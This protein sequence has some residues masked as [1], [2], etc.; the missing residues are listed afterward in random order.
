MMSSLDQNILESR[1]SKYGAQVGSVTASLIW[2]DPSDLRLRADVKLHGQSTIVNISDCNREAAGGIK[3]VV[4]PEELAPLENIS[5][6]KPLN[7]EYKIYVLNGGTIYSET[8]W[9]GKFKDSER[10]IPFKVY[11]R[12]GGSMQVF[13]GVWK[14][15]NEKINC[16]CLYIFYK[17]LLYVCRR[18]Q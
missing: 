12:G 5:W 15:H 17:W 13:D 6:K 14:P 8:N 3:D 2:S 11:L 16:Y 9:D 10:C 1:L 18:S 7:G 4:I